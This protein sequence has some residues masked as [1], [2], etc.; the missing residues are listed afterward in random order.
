[1]D[2]YKLLPHCV[3]QRPARVRWYSHT[4]ST[5]KTSNCMF[6]RVITKKTILWTGLF[7]LARPGATPTQEANTNSLALQNENH[8]NS[9]QGPPCR[10][11]QRPP[12]DWSKFPTACGPGI[13]GHL[14][15]SASQFMNHTSKKN[16]DCSSYCKCKLLA[17][18]AIFGGEV[19]TSKF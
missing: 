15:L 10:P 12:A 1:M 8:E 9:L 11:H 2:Q 14:N 18:L 5:Q 16:R 7:F 19:P 4:F 3:P 13:S 17:L 6:Y